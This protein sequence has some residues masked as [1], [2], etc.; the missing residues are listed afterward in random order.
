MQAEAGKQAY[1]DRLAGKSH[2]KAELLRHRRAC[3]NMQ[4]DRRADSR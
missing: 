4:E 3:R 1:V 2:S